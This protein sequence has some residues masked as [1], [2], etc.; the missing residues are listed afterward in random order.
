MQDSIQIL[1]LT[2]DEIGWLTDRIISKVKFPRSLLDSLRQFSMLVLLFRQHA[3]PEGHVAEIPAC[4]ESIRV[5]SIPPDVAQAVSRAPFYLSPRVLYP[6]IL[7]VLVVVQANFS[8]I[9][10]PYGSFPLD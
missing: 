10:R 3:S 6:G 1:A 2:F 9:L 4:R 5:V 7:G 8:S